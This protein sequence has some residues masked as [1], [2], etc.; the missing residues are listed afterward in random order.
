MLIHW[1]SIIYNIIE[2]ENTLLEKIDYLY[3]YI[4][5]CRV[6]NESSGLYKL[7]KIIIDETYYVPC[8][9]CVYINYK[10][11][12]KPEVSVVLFTY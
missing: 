5:M 3:I 6:P 7:C 12:D 10:I 8:Y 2:E 1:S 9:V 11:Y 4:C